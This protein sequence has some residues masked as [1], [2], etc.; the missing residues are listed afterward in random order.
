MH[1][2]ATDEEVTR[3][4]HVNLPAGYKP[5]HQHPVVFWFHGWGDDPTYFPFVDIGQQH[6]VI[7]VYPLGMDDEDVEPG[8]GRISWNVGD[9]N[10]T[11]TC[12]SMTESACYKSCKKLKMCS[13]CNCFTCIDDVYFVKTLIAK[14]EEDFCVD[15]SK[16][17]VSG[18]SNGGMFTYYLVSQIPELVNGW[19]LMFGQPMV[20]YLNTPKAAAQ[21]YLL[22]LHGRQDTCLPPAG[23]IDGDDSWIYESLDNTFYLWGLVQGCDI[24]SW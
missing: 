3:S 21:S 10:S 11:S 20:G 24:S 18:A 15:E 14:I 12:T 9:A 16:L 19:L 1:D 5:G 6:Q 13:R 4:Y 8:Q 22:S 2:P 17:Y 23:G 7:S